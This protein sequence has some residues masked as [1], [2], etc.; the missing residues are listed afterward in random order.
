MASFSLLVDMNTFE[1]TSLV[2]T[3]AITLIPDIW[4]WDSEAIDAGEIERRTN[5]EGLA[6]FTLE[7]T[8]V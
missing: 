3:E 8:Y 7:S 2:G 6:T 5:S 1:G 4:V